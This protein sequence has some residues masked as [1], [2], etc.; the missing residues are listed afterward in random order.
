EDFDK[1]ANTQDKKIT[2]AF[3][4]YG[5]KFINNVF[6]LLQSIDSIYNGK[7]NIIFYHYNIDKEYLDE[8]QQ[9][10]PYV[11]MKE[12]KHKGC[13]SGDVEYKTAQ[14]SLIWKEILDDHPNLINIVLMDADMMVVKKMGE[15]FI[16][17]F[18]VGFCYKEV[19]DENP[20]WPING[21]LML[22][23]NS[24]L[25]RSFFKEW[26]RLTIETQKSDKLSKKNGY[27]LWG[28]GDQVS[29][30]HI[31]NTRNPEDYKHG[32]K[33]SN[34]DFLGFPMK[35]INESR[36][37]I[38]SIK[39]HI[40]HYKGKSWQNVL[41]LGIFSKRRPK[42]TCNIL[43][44][45][46]CKVLKK[47]RNR[48]HKKLGK[49]SPDFEM[50]YWNNHNDD[51]YINDIKRVYNVFDVDNVILDNIGP[52]NIDNVVEVGGGAYGGA[53]RLFPFANS[54]YS[55]DIAMNEFL[56]KGKIPSNINCIKSDFGDLPI[57]TNS[58]GVV[59]AWEV[60]DHALTNKHFNAGIT[61]LCRI[62][63]PGGLLFFNHPL[64][65][66]SKLGHT[67]I[68]D[69]KEIIDSFINQGL[70]IVSEKIINNEMKHH[71]E[72]HKEMCIIFRKHD[73][74]KRIPDDIASLIS[75]VGN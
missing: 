66:I 13:E 61:E 52:D 47:W 6:I 9:I 53:L 37:I 5:D 56:K 59:F 70:Y 27:T 50:K 31:F 1:L 15:F 58:A 35:Y 32:L 7:V 39:T 16:K 65:N 54:K 42:A 8:I 72:K 33:I 23:K 75:N 73:L 4:A 26:V 40:I 29:L 51:F 18:D 41:R 71:P 11:L 30:G 38:P 68:K 64:N 20:N 67:V 44:E 10:L 57:N 12:T 74:K 46:N 28:G 17:K 36:G 14:K 63:K 34:L 19:D 60:L 3:S 62:L 45:L 22:I 55:I 48:R 24:E 2:F 69:E 43:Y 49:W 21:G 25:V